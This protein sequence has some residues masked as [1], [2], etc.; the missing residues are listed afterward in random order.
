MSRRFAAAA[1]LLAAAAC[2]PAAFIPGCRPFRGT[3][4]GPHAARLSARPTSVSGPPVAAGQRP[5]GVA[6]TRDALLRVPAAADGPTAARGPLPLLVLFHGAGGDAAG[7]M[8]PLA[9][10]A[11]RYGV[12]L[13]SPASR[14][15]TWDAIRGG[16]EA[17][18]EQ[19][20][21]ALAAT[22]SAVAIDPER[23]GVAGFSDGASYALGLGLANG[24]L[25]GRI[26]A[27]SPGFVP[28]GPRHGRPAVFVSHGRADDVLPIR[29]TS[30]KIVP[31]LERDGCSV[32]YRE[33][34]GG[35]SVPPRI[36]G[37]ALDWLAW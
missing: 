22:F 25:F 37:E 13:L 5:L 12:V 16:F 17:D 35:H 31:A 28:A 9:G 3:D 21:A 33:F 30:R 15:G 36:A 26:M 7:G 34:D 14:S 23:I 2:V 29:S 27:F 18:V 20:D 4:A 8:S 6:A 24:D 10:L 32:R 19:V 11:D 1:G